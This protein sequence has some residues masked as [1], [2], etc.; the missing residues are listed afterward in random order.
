MIYR[1]IVFKSLSGVSATLAEF[2]SL[3]QDE[4]INKTV[5]DSW[6]AV[7]NHEEHLKNPLVTRYLLNTQ[8]LVIQIYYTIL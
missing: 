1:K 3:N 6:V 2:R 4:V 8:I 7:L 5:V